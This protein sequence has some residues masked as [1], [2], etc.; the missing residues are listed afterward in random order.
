MH[1]VAPI[2][3]GKEEEEEE[4]EESPFRFDILRKMNLTKKWS[5]EFILHSRE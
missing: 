4:E 5:T 2:F 3:M 1:V